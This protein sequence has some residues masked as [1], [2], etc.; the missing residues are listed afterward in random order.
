MLQKEF[1]LLRSYKFPTYNIKY[2]KSGKNLKF[3]LLLSIPSVISAVKKEHKLVA[4]LINKENI[5]GIISDNR[6]GVYSS[7]IPSVYITH[8]LNVLSGKTTGITSKTH[9]KI[10]KNFNECWVPDFKDEPSFSG[11]LGHLETHDFNLKYIGVLS[12]FK[13]E[14]R[15]ILNNLLVLL[16]GPEPQRTLLEEKL[17]IELKNYKGKVLFVRGVLDNS[18]NL[19]VSNNF[20]IVNYL[21]SK[22]LEKAINQSEIV[23]ARSGY[24]TIMDLAICGKKAF[25]IPTPGQF[26]QEYLAKKLND[27]LIAPSIKQHEFTFEKLKEIDNYQGFIKNVSNI[28]LDLFK[29]F[30]GK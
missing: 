1:P 16:S 3:K 8:Q 29:L 26:E 18:S 20:K 6:F 24:S 25:F 30:E 17:L 10:I 9:Q 23:I 5:A 19:R 21:L 14:K 28:D 4:Q 15:E 7:K 22:N 2:S 12:R 11:N 13:Y 27:K